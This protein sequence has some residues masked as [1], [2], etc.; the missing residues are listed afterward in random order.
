VTDAAALEAADAAL[1]RPLAIALLR[2]DAADSTAEEA[3][4][5]IADAE[6][7]ADEAAEE[8]AEVADATAEPAAEEASGI[9][10]GTPAPAQVDSTA[11][12]V[13]FWSA[14]EQAPCT[15]GWTEA[16]SSAPCLQWQAKS[17]REEQPSLL[18]GPMKHVS[19]EYTL[20]GVDH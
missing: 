12:M 18:R 11:S 9:S 10:M 8:A 19:W 17:V 20:I 13:V 2:L 14:A 7:A 6:A 4:E 16:S 3:P 5:T 1:L 15:Q